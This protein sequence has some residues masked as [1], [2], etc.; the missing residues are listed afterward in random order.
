VK[1]TAPNPRRPLG[2]TL[3]L[4]A[5]ATLYG[6]LPLMEVYF[7]WRLNMTTSEA[8]ILGGVDI[9]AWNW[10]EG[11]LGVVMLGVCALAWRGKPPWIRRVLMALLILVTVANLYRIIE[12]WRDQVDPIFDGQAQ[13]VL[14]NFLRC[15]FPALVIVPLYVLWYI[16]RAPAR[17]FYARGAAA[18][19]QKN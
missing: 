16:N 5:T 12:A 6:L 18:K 13:E 4:I 2:L 14:R 7:L 8:Y 17:A 19:S 3:A 10:L 15:Q 11:A 1:A 9:S